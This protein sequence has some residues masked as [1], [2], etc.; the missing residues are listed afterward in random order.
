MIV[1]TRPG[2]FPTGEIV[3]T[4]R[5]AAALTCGDLSLAL[6]RHLSGDR[7]EL[8][9]HDWE[10]NQAALKGGEDRL[11]S[12]YKSEAGTKFYLITEW[13]RSVTTFLLPEDCSG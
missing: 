7:G 6:D 13:D 2:K 10:L 11:F 1:I 12:V 9:L 4:Q 3:I 5:A 8:D